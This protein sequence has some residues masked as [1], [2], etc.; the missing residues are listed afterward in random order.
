MYADDTSLTLSANDAA[1][2]EEKLN[3]DISEVQKWLQSNKLA[4]IKCK[5]KKQICTIIGS[6]YRLRHS[7]ED[8]NVRVDS[9]QL[10]W[11]TTY[12]YLGIE[13]DEASGW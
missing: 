5:K 10:M 3:K 1:T 11:T 6:H 13:V 4:H 2:L 12:R 9:Q 7:Y 8:L